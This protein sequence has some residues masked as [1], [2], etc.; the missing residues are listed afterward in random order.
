ML[1]A[2]W[3]TLEDPEQIGHVGAGKKASAGYASASSVS[4]EFM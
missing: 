3:T 2:G 4:V 1:N